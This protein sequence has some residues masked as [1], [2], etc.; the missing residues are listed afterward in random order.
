MLHCLMLYQKSNSNNYSPEEHLSSSY[1][2]FFIPLSRS[3]TLIS[4]DVLLPGCGSPLD[5]SIS[6]TFP[7]E[8]KRL[9]ELSNFLHRIRSK[10]WKIN[11]YYKALFVSCAQCTI[12]NNKS[13]F[14]IINKLLLSPKSSSSS[15]TWIFDILKKIG[16]Q[17]RLNFDFRL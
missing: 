2:T 10:N 12:T 5:V 15:K 13:K 9:P 3:S 16:V 11:Q 8:L 17:I 7:S 1:F 6:L 4:R 14:F